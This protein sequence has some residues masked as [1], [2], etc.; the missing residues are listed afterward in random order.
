[1]IVKRELATVAIG[2][3]TYL[4][5]AV[6]VDAEEGE[7]AQVG[8]VNDID[9]YAVSFADLCYLHICIWSVLRKTKTAVPGAA[10]TFRITGGKGDEDSVYDLAH[11]LA[12]EIEEVIFLELLLM[13]LHVTLVDSP[14]ERVVNLGVVRRDNDGLCARGYGV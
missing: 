6:G 11:L 3:D 10:R 9:R 1:M 7:G 14:L 2:S 12:P 8:R 5:R 13:P 4:E